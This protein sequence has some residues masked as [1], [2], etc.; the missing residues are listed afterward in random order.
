MSLLALSLLKS[1][2]SLLAGSL[3]M[4]AAPME[5]RM[6]IELAEAAVG[7]AELE[8]LKAEIEKLEAQQKEQVEEL[9][10]ALPEE[11]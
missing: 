5:A 11:K 10:K 3:F 4:F 7:G 9:R 8:E 2:F 1:Q 6:D